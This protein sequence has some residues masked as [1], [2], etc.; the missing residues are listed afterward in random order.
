VLVVVVSSHDP[1]PGKHIP[2]LEQ[3][4]PGSQSSLELHEYRS[5]IETLE[6][7]SVVGLQKSCPQ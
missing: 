7:G 3:Q 5:N 6:P 1:G 4:C 2:S